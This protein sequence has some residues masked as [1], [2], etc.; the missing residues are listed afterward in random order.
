MEL[1]L[2]IDNIV[3][4]AI[5][6]GK[7]PPESQKKAR[8]IGLSGALVLRIALL[9]AIT[10]IMK[11]TTPL[12]TLLNHSF[13]GRDI[14]LL[15]GGFFLIGKGTYEIH[16]RIERPGGVPSA[17][18]GA[19]AS[20]AGAI[21][22]IMLLDM[23][24]S[25]DSIVTAVGMARNIVV[26]ITAILLAVAG[27]MIF[28]GAVSAFIDRHPTIK[29]LALSFLILI[30]VLLVAEGFGKEIERGYVYFAMVFS[31]FVEMINMKIRKQEPGGGIT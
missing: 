29:I 26:M 18:P 25:L 22:Q 6:T 4:L 27:M 3:V 5:V 9:S 11:L 1:V 13:S 10:A 20:F 14:I 15:L 28:A 31:L 12:I 24:F 21:V 8:L 19:K 17:G 2:G 30:G 7:L 16:E 23:V